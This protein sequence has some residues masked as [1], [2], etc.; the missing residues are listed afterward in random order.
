L[1]TAAGGFEIDQSRRVLIDLWFVMAQLTDN[2][3]I[4]VCP[5]CGQAT[6]LLRTVPRV[7]GLPAL[8]VFVCPACN[9]VET[10]ED[11]RAA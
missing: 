9:E 11:K 4:L 3:P 8:L 5:A 1:L 7:G 10:R 6:K 2:L